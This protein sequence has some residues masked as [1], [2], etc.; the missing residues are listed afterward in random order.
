[1]IKLEPFKP[2]DFDLLVSW[3][4]SKELLLQIAGNYF[5]Y[6]LTPPQLQNYLNDKRSFAFSIVE[7]SANK[8]IGHSEIILL[9]NK[10]CKL[11][12][13]LIGDKANRGKGVGQKVVNELL[14]ISFENFSAEKAELYVY[15]WNTGAI[16][17]YERVG[18]V[19]NHDKQ[20]L[21]E[22][23]GKVWK[24]LN[25]TIDKREWLSLQQQ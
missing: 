3:I 25:M 19:I 20:I 15:D 13:I 2:S 23:D 10:V 8:V 21:T 1:M 17:A 24:A 16:K 5:S 6:P 7:T 12:K 22:V 11:D 14:A 9:D 4:D 18:F